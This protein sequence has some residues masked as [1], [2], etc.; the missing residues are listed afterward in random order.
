MA[1]APASTPVV[2]EWELMGL[3]CCSQQFAF[4][5]SPLSNEPPSGKTRNLRAIL[6]ERRMGAASQHRIPGVTG[7]SRLGGV[8]D[9]KPC[10]E[11]FWRDPLSRRTQML[12]LEDWS[13][14]VPFSSRASILP[15]CRVRH[16]ATVSFRQASMTSLSLF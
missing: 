10:F 15:V 16:Q 11:H 2:P 14:C 4:T 13:P 6:G 7:K 8:P 9:S 5:H 3:T 1:G 12:S